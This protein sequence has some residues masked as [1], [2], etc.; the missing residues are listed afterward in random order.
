MRWILAVAAL[1]AFVGVSS[2][3]AQA[4]KQGDPAAKGQ[5][6]GGAAS[7]PASNETPKPA[8]KP[9]SAGH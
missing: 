6:A 4:P 7:H 1:V 2:A 8:A 5:P 9:G 3:Y